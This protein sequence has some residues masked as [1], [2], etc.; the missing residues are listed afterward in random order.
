M[1]KYVSHLLRIYFIFLFIFSFAVLKGQQNDADF[2][3]LEV[4]TRED[5]L[6]HSEVVDISSITPGYMLFGTYDGVNMYNAYA[7]RELVK[8]ST[9]NNELAY[10]TYED[11]EKNI[12]L[13]ISK[14]G[15]YKKEYLSGTYRHY[16]FPENINVLDIYDIK[17]V[18]PNNI[19]F[20]TSSGLWVYAK[21]QDKILRHEE[22]KL[23]DKQIH[24]I[25]VSDTGYIWLGTKD[26]G[27]FRMHKDT[28]IQLL[29]EIPSPT[30]HDIVI[31][32]TKIYAACFGGGLYVIDRYT[33]ITEH[34]PVINTDHGSIENFINAIALWNNDKILLGTYAGIFI[35][36]TSLKSF[37]KLSS[38]QTFPEY[39]QDVPVLSLFLDAEAN[40]LWAGTKG[41][42]VYKYYLNNHI[43]NS[44]LFDNK[45]AN[46]PLNAIHYILPSADK[47][48][49]IGSGD[50]LV[51]TNQ[52][53]EIEKIKRTNF[54]NS[55]DI[56]TKIE[57]LSADKFLVSVWSK[58]LWLFEPKKDLYRRV[59]IENTKINSIYDIKVTQDGILL[60]MHDEGLI[61]LNKH[62]KTVDHKF[63]DSL[64]KKGLII[65]KILIDHK[66]NI[67]VGSQSR[68][69]FVLDPSA[70]DTINPLQSLINSKLHSEINILDFFQDTNNNI[71]I[72][73]NGAG[74][75]VFNY[76]LGEIHSLH[77]ERD[78]F[79]DVI[80]SIAEDTKGNLWLQTNKGIT[81]FNYSTAKKAINRVQSFDL[82][83]GLPNKEFSFS[84][85]Y[86]HNGRLYF[87]SK[88][89][90]ISI[91][92]ESLPHAEPPKLVL[93]DI[94]INN[95]SLE[96]YPKNK[97]QTN[98]EYRGDLLSLKTLNLKHKQNRI[99]VS[100]AALNYYKT[101]G[102]K[103]MIRL[104]GFDNEWYYLDN[105]N[106][107]NYIN[108]PPGNYLLQI[109]ASNSNNIWNNDGI[110]I[111]INISPPWYITPFAIISYIILF[112]IIIWLVRNFTLSKAKVVHNRKLEKLRIENERKLALFKLDFFTKVTH[113]IRTPITLIRGPLEKMITKN[114]DPQ[115]NEKY[116]RIIKSNSDKLYQLT[117]QILD[118]RKIDEKN[119]KVEKVTDDIIPFLAEITERFQ[120]FAE[121][122][123][124]NLQ[125]VTQ[126]KSLPMA[127]D[128]RILDRILSNLLSNGIKFTPDKGN[129]V[130]SA[131]QTSTI[132]HSFL[133]ISVTDTGY[134]MKPEEIEQIFNPFYQSESVSFNTLPGTGLGLTLV[135]ELTH[136]HNGKVE[137]ISS[138]KSGTTFEITLN[139]DK[140]A[141]THLSKEI[142]KDR[143]NI[144]NNHPVQ[145]DKKPGL[146]KRILIVEDN[147]ELNEF[148]V[149][150]LSDKYRTYSAYDGKEGIK[151]A[152]RFMPDLII[153]DVMM[154]NMNGI[155]FC[156][157]I[158]SHALTCHIS[159]LILTI[160]A[161]ESSMISGLQSGADDYIVKPF[162]SDMLLMK[163][164]NILV[165]RENL[166][167]RFAQSFM[168]SDTDTTKASNEDPFI[169]K[170][171]SFIKEHIAD[172]NLSPNQIIKHLNV[173]RS[174]FYLKVKNATGMTVQEIIQNTRLRIAYQEI[175]EGKGNVSET[176]YAVGFK[177]LSHFSKSFRAKFGCNPSNIS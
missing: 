101:A 95:K 91:D 9:I 106:S 83:H 118:L 6:S 42:G 115:T 139:I 172:E 144:R 29:H 71:W 76:E 39:P 125:F 54:Q 174:Q 2:Y 12:W 150:L 151:M 122:R 51:I 37:S 20:G 157:A 62:L 92:T 141:P 153:S 116:L 34:Y 27:I 74:L 33:L 168:I 77:N 117:N 177:N 138:N 24:S 128:A 87:P 142:R 131:R 89:G 108:I 36:N 32:E 3:H 123:E 84:S 127:F 31:S 161:N 56:V 86:Q 5:G 75:I 105:T 72:G 23:K 149:T 109:K 132:E 164:E 1:P 94:E 7:C 104:N 81:R 114:I 16:P 58:G 166:R 167:Q 63:Y 18:T 52:N 64:K 129:V 175:K 110:K 152:N 26:H 96:D 162:N 61:K 73:T 159:F 66:G 70:N 60:A 119:M 30:I 133:H 140:S 41:Y 158:K 169:Q 137:V 135:K 97:I 170:M 45:K 38:S 160:K 8:D 47:K 57:K 28:I 147:P 99:N 22:K 130:I 13:G 69:I 48:Y 98:K 100:F 40:L 126:L 171:T 176:A 120:P 93:T 10:A 103:Y 165:Y 50:G 17:E 146:N 102:S 121:T 156:K 163:I 90:I 67:W 11:S 44:F 80:Y 143:L 55:R 112:L 49:L 79:Y 25:N 154:P 134:G 148:L 46:E 155:E 59:E 15:I 82:E 21:E 113:E 43:F 14:S 88:E 65:K 53:F 4:V 111:K 35:F 107:F 19:L 68:G 85:S 124:I 136:L 173:S 145:V 78:I